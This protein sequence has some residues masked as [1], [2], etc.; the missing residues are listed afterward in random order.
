MSAHNVLPKK[1]KR[2][3]TD[4]E[5]ANTSYLHRVENALANPRKACQA[6][7]VSGQIYVGRTDGV[8]RASRRKTVLVPSP[9]NKLP[10]KAQFHLEA[11]GCAHERFAFST[12][13]TADPHAFLLHVVREDM[14]HGWSC[15]LVV[16]WFA[17]SPDPPSRVGAVALRSADAV[18]LCAPPGAGEIVI[19]VARAHAHAA[20]ELTV[21]L[22]ERA[23]GVYGRVTGAPA[24]PLPYEAVLVWGVFA[25]ADSAQ[26][27]GAHDARLHIAMP[28]HDAESDPVARLVEMGFDREAAQ[29]ALDQAF[30]NSTNAVEQLLLAAA[31]AA[32][33]SANAH[34]SPDVLEQMESIELVQTWVGAPTNVPAEYQRVRQAIAVTWP[35]MAQSRQQQLM[36]TMPVERGVDI[37]DGEAILIRLIAKAY[38]LKSTK[39]VRKQTDA[40]FEPSS[41]LLGDACRMYAELHWR[42]PYL[43]AALLT[44]IDCESAEGLQV[45]AALLARGGRE[46]HARKMFVFATVLSRYAAIRESASR[47]ADPHEPAETASAEEA[48]RTALVHYVHMF[49]DD[50]KEKAFFS[51]FISPT[52]RYFTC[53]GDYIMAGDTDVHGSNCYLAVLMST[54]AVQLPRV[55]LLHDDGKGFADFLSADMAGLSEFWADPSRAGHP[56]PESIRP[57]TTVA[58]NCFIFPG[59]NPA[60]IANAAVSDDPQLAPRRA[61]LARYLEAFANYFT[62]THV[63]DRL[64]SHMLQAEAPTGAL[65]LAWSSFM[66]ASGAERGEAGDF[67]SWVWDLAEIPA[68]LHEDRAAAFFVW[69][70][71]LQA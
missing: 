40:I 49:V 28:A 55:P 43:R 56:L 19:C 23:D 33:P 51:V 1:K 16:D 10:P 48:A 18:A 31:Q 32:A 39:A 2:L 20:D 27:T 60:S 64:V 63:I 15:A 50:L 42:R 53:K 21:V 67:A 66:T 59:Y 3:S 34:V 12:E 7:R 44:L 17:V 69:L 4:D 58:T 45:I 9:N 30:G 8:E 46:C 6:L 52:E 36:N 25:Q 65:A 26:F 22:D 24:W 13:L 61:H 11:S 47:A 29:Q 70:G 14:P 54:L 62:R 5:T 37:D 35:L 71:V 68:V 38:A 41:Y 57:R